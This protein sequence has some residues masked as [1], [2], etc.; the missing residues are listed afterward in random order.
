MRRAVAVCLVLAGCRAE[1]LDLSLV[2]GPEI[3]SVLLVVDDGDELRVSAQDV[4]V[5][6]A[7]K[8]PILDTYVG[9]Y[10]LEL[11]AFLYAAPVAS[12]G[13]N[14]GELVQDPGGDPI[15]PAVAQERAA[16]RGAVVEPFSPI[17]RD[18]LGQRIRELRLSRTTDAIDCIDDGGCYDLSAATPSACLRPC[19]IPEPPDRP[20][21]PQDPDLAA[22]GGGWSVTD[23]EGTRVCAPWV[24]MPS[25]GPEEIAV[26]GEAGCSHVGPACPAGM[27]RE[28]LSGPVLYAVSGG[29]P[30]DGS[31]AAPFASLGEALAVA[32]PQTIIALGKGTFAETVT[33]PIDIALVGACVEQT[34]VTSVIARGEVTLDGL[35][36]NAADGPILASGAAVGD[37]H[38]PVGDIADARGSSV[39]AAV[40]DGDLSFTR[41]RAGVMR[42]GGRADIEDTLLTGNLDVR[43]GSAKVQRA[44]FDAAPILV[45]DGDLHVQ[46]AIVRNAPTAGLDVGQGGFAEVSL[47]YFHD[48]GLA[49]V[50]TS[51]DA[52]VQVSSSILTADVPDCSE[53]VPGNGVRV[54]GGSMVELSRSIVARTTGSAI[55]LPE[56]GGTVVLTDVSIRDVGFQGRLANGIHL[57]PETTLLAERVSVMRTGNKA[58]DID[59]ARASLYDI[60]I[61]DSGL[62]DCEVCSGICAFKT[63]SVTVD[64]LEVVDSRGRGLMAKD[65]GCMLSAGD[66]HL[67]G[68]M[69]SP[70]CTTMNPNGAARVGQC[71][72]AT[73]GGSLEIFRFSIEACGAL[74]VRVEQLFDLEAETSVLL[75]DGDIKD[76]PTGIEL[77]VAG[78]PLQ[79]IANRVRYLD[80]SVNVVR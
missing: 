42:V 47:A 57:E 61:R 48:N 26:P 23:V 27:F 12:L 10:P 41:G 15:P 69:P 11:V 44:V 54:G 68:A 73:D 75:S 64:W 5:G 1:R 14:P 43:G 35:T 32:S 63:S 74:G 4:E 80:N 62:D 20:S 34:V 16:V 9:A 77:L 65:A 37:L 67:T 17:L 56:A 58:I 53:M 24:E 60:E 33:I 36:V 78:Y 2:V 38:I 51:G 52:R 70:P 22:C 31:E 18:D 8:V 46:Q 28:G 55:Y 21:P 40:V 79:R 45:G 49:G 76:N 39:D 71:A 50:R 29:P 72:S 7:L 30:G 19:P 3:R 13:L 59:G 66:V 6:G 25:C